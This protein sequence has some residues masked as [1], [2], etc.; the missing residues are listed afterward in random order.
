MNTLQSL[1]LFMALVSRPQTSSGPMTPGEMAGLVKN[2]CFGCHSDNLSMGGLS[3][4]HFDPP[5]LDPAI[6]AMM[7]TE[8]QNGAMS[9]AGIPKPSA[10]TVAAFTRG[11]AAKAADAERAT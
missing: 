6:A 7:V 5:N 1:V 3:F 9:A 10:G 11:L 4:E 8:V 2:Y